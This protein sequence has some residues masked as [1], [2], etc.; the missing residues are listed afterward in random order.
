MKKIVFATNNKHKI[1]EINRIIGDQIKL[2]SLKEI[3][4]SE[5]IPEVEPT[6]EGN[7][8]AKSWYVYNKYGYNCFADDT[9]LEVKA[10]DGQPG[11]RSARYAGDECDPEKNI[12]KVLTGLK[13]KTNRKARFRT[14]ISL[15]IDG[16]ENLFEGIVEGKILETKTGSD[17]FGYDPVF[18][19]DG[20]DQS[21]AE[22]PLDLK[23]QISHRGKATRKLVNYLIEAK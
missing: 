3:R 18:L 21:F 22:M 11:V 17:G 7:A 6:I 16:K 5:E 2:L 4:C 10:L 9:G 14:V 8:S 19:P 1:K 13:G 20:Y 12:I 15:I 23:N